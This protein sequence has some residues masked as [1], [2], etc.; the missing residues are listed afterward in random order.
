VR[1]F[2]RRQVMTLDGAEIC[3]HLREV[4]ESAVV[5]GP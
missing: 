2:D 1:A 3:G 5:M 4:F